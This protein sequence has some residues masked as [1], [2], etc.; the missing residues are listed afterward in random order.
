M[1]QV[2]A[3]IGLMFD[4]IILARIGLYPDKY[5]SRLHK[6]FHLIC[7]LISTTIMMLMSYINI[8]TFDSEHFIKSYGK[9]ILNIV[10]II[11]QVFIIYYLLEIDTDKNKTGLKFKNLDQ[12]SVT[13][14]MILITGIICALSIFPIIKPLI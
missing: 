4:I 8:F 5:I 13:L 11:T 14:I 7:L 6:N 10:Y 12:I 9:I 3:K 2:L 1:Y